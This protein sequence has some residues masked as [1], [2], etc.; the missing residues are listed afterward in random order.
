MSG[1]HTVVRPLTP[2][3]VVDHLVDLIAGRAEQRLRVLLDG[4]PSTRPDRLADLLVEPLRARGRAAVTVHAKDFL[5][6]ASVRFEHGRTDSDGFYDRV[7]LGALARE[8]IDPWGPGGADRYLPTLWDAHRD[9][10]TRAPYADVP[11]AGVLLVDGALLLGR[12]LDVDLSVHLALRPSTVAR[13]ASSEDGWTLPAYARYEE[14]VAPGET[15]DV[16]LR[17]DDPR[18]PALVVRG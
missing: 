6:P 14:E 18:H 1:S 12:W 9:R 7:D 8:V 5:R 2:D 3:G 10:A 16:V 13:R 4:H 15:A 17:V 11:D